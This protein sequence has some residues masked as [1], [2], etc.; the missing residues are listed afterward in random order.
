M[1][2]NKEIEKRPCRKLPAPYLLM[3]ATTGD[4]S[5][6]MAVFGPLRL[7]LEPLA[8]P[9]SRLRTQPQGW[10]RFLQWDTA[11]RARASWSASHSPRPPSPIPFPCWKG[12]DRASSRKGGNRHFPVAFRLKTGS[13]GPLV[14]MAQDNWH[15]FRLQCVGQ[16]PPSFPVTS[17]AGQEP[18]FTRSHVL[19]AQFRYLNISKSQ[20][21]DSSFLPT[22]YLF[23][24]LI[25][26]G[27]R[28]PW[29][30][31]PVPSMSLVRHEASPCST[32]GQYR[33]RL[34]QEDPD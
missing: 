16:P 15:F 8:V 28:N 18:K 20:D 22:S 1:A 3:G 9:L 13:P 27:R 30:A 5:R 12:F 17:D 31:P 7:A 11:S 26:D 34:I 24:P 33:E 14:N 29:S 10:G 32:S 2:P 23:P 6:G 19:S 4:R 21:P 25:Q